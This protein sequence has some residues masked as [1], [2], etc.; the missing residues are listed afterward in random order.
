MRPLKTFWHV[1]TKSNT[2]L[3]YYKVLVHSPLSFSLK[4]FA[5]YFFIFAVCSC[6]L[7]TFRT[8]IPLGEFINRLPQHLVQAY[9]EELII[10]INR[11]QVSTNVDEPYKISIDV[12]E[13]IVQ[14]YE[15]NVLSASDQSVDYLLVIDTN[16]TPDQIFAQNTWALLSLNTITYINSNGFAET[17][18]LSDVQNI[19]IDQERVALIT[20]Q[21]LTLAYLVVPILIAITAVFYIAWGIYTVI[22]MLVT[23]LL[24]YVIGRIM[25]RSVTYKQAYQVSLHL[26]LI[27]ITIFAVFSFIGLPVTFWFKNTLF[28][29]VVGTIIMTKLPKLE[30][31]VK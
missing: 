27:P 19:I 8:F 5:L 20:Q 24:L 28:V 22:V 21:A 1:F 18:P 4:Y 16:A 2:S 25:K 17:I 9:P 30:T 10:S 29:L 23:A 15:Q 26:V 13:P 6:I 7:L 14:D 31:G 3:G 11:G 12:L